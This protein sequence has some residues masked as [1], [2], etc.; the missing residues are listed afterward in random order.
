[1]RISEIFRLGTRQAELDFVDI[2]IDRDTPLFIDPF[3][4]STRADPWSIGASHTIRS[5]FQFFI[6]LI[7]AEEFEDARRLFDYLHEPNETCLGMSKGRP[8]GNGIGDDDA[9]RIFVSLAESKA[10][11]TG[12][13]HDL[14]DC[15]IFV[16]GIDKDKTS[17]MATNIIR[18]HLLDYTIQQCRL[19]DIP[20]EQDAPSGFYWD[21]ARRQWESDT[22]SVL[23]AH[24]KKILLVPKAVVSYS[25]RH[26]PQQFHQHFVL[27]FLQHEHLR[28]RSALVQQTVRRGSVVREFVTKKSLKERGNAALT[29]DF[30]TN[31]TNAHPQVFK[32]F[33]ESPRIRVGS[34]PI[35]QFSDYNVEEVANYLR[36]KL[37]AIP[38][39]T[40]H[41]TDFHRT[42]ASILDFLFYPRLTNPIIEREI[43]DGRK[44]VDL[45]FDNGAFEGFFFRLPNQAQLSCPFIFIECK[46]Y[47]REVGNPEV[48]QLS[49]RFS[50][51][52]GKVGILVCRA[53]EDHALL[54]RRCMDTY[55][56]QRGLILPFIDTDLEAGLQERA[57]GVD[58]PLETRLQ[59]LYTQVAF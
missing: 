32:E 51:N 14:E 42:A 59:E 7:Y 45:T 55:R 52:R 23:L 17:D 36:E 20:L 22:T 49:G 25:N 33:R 56:D 24:G 11:Q 31:F 21:A 50:P 40:E 37:R 30:L 2:D 15:R 26:T 53:V 6:N 48:D 5:F 38:V 35:E 19:W 46:N 43:H 18:K 34:L 29:K 13:L 54:L 44:R 47:G 12:L 57:T 10:A 41:A 39:G 4:L 16:D 28:M 58:F 3:V 27:N 9:E 8:R 1:M